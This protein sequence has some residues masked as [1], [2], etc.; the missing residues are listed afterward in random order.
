LGLFVLEYLCAIKPSLGGYIVRFPDVPQAVTE[1][2][3]EAEALAWAEDALVVALTGYQDAG[4]DIPAP[5]RPA[6][7]QPAVALP[8]YI[9]IKLVIYQAMREL[10]VSQAELARRLECD[11]RQV[12]RLLDPDHRSRLDLMERA[13]AA[14]G[15]RLVVEVQDAA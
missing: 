14:L 6:P 15:K 12:R 2:D 1:A 9:A 11:P 13:L 4:R 7:G 3:T 5:S 8:P 10:G